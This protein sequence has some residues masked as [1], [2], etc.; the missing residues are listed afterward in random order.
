MLILCEEKIVICSLVSS[1]VHESGHLFFMCIFDDV[2]QKVDF[3]LFGMR[4]DRANRT[5]L[6]YK[7]EIVIAYGGIIF[8]L[9]LS[10]LCFILSAFLNKKI[11]L[12][13]SVINLFIAVVNSFPVSILDSGRA[14]RCILIIS[15]GIDS[16]GY[17][18]D[19]ISDCFVI[20]FTI[21]STI[22]LIFY[23]INISL[24]AVNLYLI[25]ITIIKK[26]S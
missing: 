8:N 22:Y 3:S 25:F 7:K 20:I 24:F 2:P 12:E 4:I 26:W 17:Y 13:I 10:V 23:S 6:S 1:I 9:I 21:I 19:I 5:S 18:A 14:L 11:L 15:K 16:G